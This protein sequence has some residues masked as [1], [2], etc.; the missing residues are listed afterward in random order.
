MKKIMVL[1]AAAMLLF[2][3][4]GQ[5]MAAFSQN[6][7]DLI[8]VYYSTSGGTEYATDLGSVSSIVADFASL[9]PG[10]TLN[11]NN[12]LSGNNLFGLSNLS[13]YQVAYF[14]VTYPGTGSYTVSAPVGTTIIP[15][16]VANVTTPS[17]SVVST[18][19]KNV[20]TIAG[21]ATSTQLIS[22]TTSYYKSLDLQ[23]GGT[24]NGFITN[25]SIDAAISG[26]YIDQALYLFA[27]KNA[28]TATTLGDIRTLA[29][30]DTE[31]IAPAA[32][33]TPIP[34]SI[35][36]MGSSLLGLVG[37]RRKIVG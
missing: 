7:A 20:T 19:G 29:N 32:A 34:P 24:L 6:P 26:N 11:L 5:A 15:N 23:G 10:A 35:F 31:L 28:A 18:Y 9:A 17:N 1:F 16:A 21:L 25:T 14:A 27:N 37:I 2:G 13:G 33:T 8:Q 4:S 22:N 12:N 30:G 36:L 3:F